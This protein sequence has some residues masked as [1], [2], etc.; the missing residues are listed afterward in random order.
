M[1]ELF[2]LM[3]RIADNN[4]LRV[5]YEVVSLGGLSDKAGR[6]RHC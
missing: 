3:D 2:R 6:R 4:K 1:K 5:G